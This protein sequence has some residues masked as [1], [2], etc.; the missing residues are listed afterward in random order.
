[1]SAIWEF[2]KPIIH[3]LYEKVLW[4]FIYST[5]NKITSFS[6]KLNR[7]SY[8]VQFG[9]NCTALDQSKLSNF[10]ECT[11]NKKTPISRPI[12]SG[13]SGPKERISSFVD[14]LLQSIAIEQESYIKDTTDFINF[15][16]IDVVCRYNKDLYELKLPIPTSHLRKLRLNEIHFV[17]THGIVK[18][19]KILGGRFLRCFRGRH[20]KT[21][22][23]GKPTETLWL[24]EVYLF[25]VE[26]SNGGSFHFRQLR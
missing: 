12:L 9:I 11:I 24:K 2:S 5:F 23:S 15:I 6:W 22:A 21:T 20:G 13:S 7:Y 18:G 8:T 26:D 19:N 16:D 4:F 10:F 3:E 1:M 25:F 17:Q 14:S